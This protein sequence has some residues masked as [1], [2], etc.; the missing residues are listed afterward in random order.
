MLHGGSW[1]QHLHLTSSAQVSW[2]TQAL[3]LWQVRG[4]CVKKKSGL[5]QTFRCH[6][7]LCKSWCSCCGQQPWALPVYLTSNSKAAW[8]A[9]TASVREWAERA[10]EVWAGGRKLRF[11]CQNQPTA[12]FSVLQPFVH[13]RV[14]AQKLTSVNT[15][16]LNWFHVWRAILGHGIDDL[17][18]PLNVVFQ[19][20]IIHMAG[21]KFLRL[22]SKSGISECNLN[23]EWL[24]FF[25][26]MMSES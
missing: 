24:K 4:G 12:A 1:S 11:C 18:L 22:Q 5:T 15:L 14:N 8:E 3:S 9:P 13:L 25:V 20:Y 2:L 26:L 10:L 6:R 21:S 23:L 19:D 17:S 16:G 7:G